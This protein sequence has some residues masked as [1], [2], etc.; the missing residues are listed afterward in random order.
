MKQS[1]VG[2]V[3][4][5]ILENNISLYLFAAIL[6]SSRLKNF[7]FDI[8]Y[9][10]EQNWFL[11]ID[12]QSKTISYTLISSVFFIDSFSF[13]FRELHFLRIKTV[14]FIF[15]V[16]ILL[17][18]ILC[19]SYC[20]VKHQE[21]YW[22]QKA[23]ADI[24]FC[25]HKYSVFHYCMIFG[26]GFSWIHSFSLRKLTCSPSLSIRNEYLLLFHPFSVSMVMNPWVFFWIDRFSNS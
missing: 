9:Y 26:V 19:L 15:L 8:C 16:S 5:S 22:I 18:L 21:E 14:F 24:I 4:L 1:L 10:R 2:I 6:F 23:R 3:N 11:Y 13:L 17:N 20:T 12:I 25:A 7:Y